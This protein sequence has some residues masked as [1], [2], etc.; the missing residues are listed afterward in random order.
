M[1]DLNLKKV[2]AAFGAAAGLPPDERDAVLAEH[3]GENHDLRALVESMLANHDSGMGSFL[4]TPD[5]GSTVTGES[6]GLPSPVRGPG[7]HQAPETIGPYRILE[8]IGEGGM[9]V[10]YLAERTKPVRQRVAIKVIKEGMDTRAVLTRFEAERQALAL[11]D[12]PN[13]AKVLDAGET[14]QG[15]PYFV[16][17]LVK[18]EPLNKYCD[19][20][21]LTM[22]ERLEVFVPV[23]RAVQH[24]HQK[25]IIH[26]DL[27]PSNILVAIADGRPLPKVIDFG[28]AKATGKELTEKTLFTQQGQLVGTPEYM[29]PEQAG[30]G[31]L[32]I[33][34]RT[35]VY[36]LGVVLYE[37]LTGTLPFPP[38]ELRR[39]GLAEI[40]RI[41]REKD[42]PRP[43]TRVSTLGEDADVVARQ[44]NTDAS[45]LTRQL[46]GELDWILLKSM[47]KDR[48]RRYETTNDLVQDIERY[49]RDEPIL[50][51]PPSTAYQL[52][53]F[54]ARHT[55]PLVFA[56]SVFVLLLAS[57]I[58]MS[59]LYQGQRRERERASA[60][61]SKAKQTTV[62]LQDMLLSVHPSMSQGR[63]IT[64]R[65]ILEEADQS[66]RRSL[67]DEPEIQAAVQTVLGE[68][69]SGLGFRDKGIAHLE[70]ALATQLEVLGE[71]HMDV[72]RTMRSLGDI[73]RAV[74]KP[75]SSLAMLRSA[76]RIQQKLVGDEHV[77]TAETKYL[78]GYALRNT[79]E[80]GPL[81]QEALD[82]RRR[83]L[84]ENSLAVAENMRGL[85]IWYRN[86]RRDL[87][88][89]EYHLRRA[90]E[91]KRSILGED[92]YELRGCL[93]DLGAVLMS[94]GD[95]SGAASLYR[96]ALDVVT[97]V[98]GEDFRSFSLYKNNL[99][100]A[101]Y[102]AGDHEESE[103]IY[104]DALA[105]LRRI[106]SKASD[107]M[108]TYVLMGLGRVLIDKGELAEA[109]Q[110]LREALEIIQGLYAQKSWRGAYCEVIL[111]SCLEA[112]GRRGEADALMGEAF[113]FLEESQCP[114]LPMRDATDRMIRFYEGS[115]TP[116]AAD[117]YRDLR[118]SLEH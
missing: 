18:G 37:L 6:R 102:F 82:T 59:I 52:K 92:R 69:Y 88:R 68:T 45:R 50:A 85:G 99:A 110:S 76:L 111:G 48:T 109:E 49:L 112:S 16:M 17:E 98:L 100:A 25:G 90:L 56:S 113:E 114:H 30:M 55:L 38:E 64:V 54:A 21:T 27:K 5:I 43:S 3:C 44:R 35:D 26:R 117:Y 24:A 9:G 57:T 97:K 19:R 116:D 96:E 61:A 81:L 28:V 74:M 79:E 51:R 10:V 66:V 101:L 34:T 86:A 8:T 103:R 32:D 108:L 11:M 115:G 95:Y 40:Q 60:E 31:A 65:E 67:A 14:E 72:A 71:E 58:A 13:I 63:E 2:Q 42:P 87:D 104:R 75:D 80:G 78:L 39:A 107:R 83:L 94:L 84:G 62:F 105:E 1:D 7:P 12:H 46:R 22:R 29:S 89:A 23:C 36:S 47:E 41:I 70:E 118:K 20:H 93:L 53:K 4:C 15:R 106:D 77:E 33:D 73:Y 91:L